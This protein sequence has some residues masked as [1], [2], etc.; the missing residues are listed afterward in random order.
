M[1]AMNPTLTYDGC[2]EQWKINLALSRIRAFD[3]P[4]DQ[5]PDLLQRLVLAMSQFQFDP[6]NGAK[7]STALYTLINHQLNSVRRAQMRE[8]QRLA[9][10]RARNIIRSIAQEDHIDLRLDVRLAVA[11][12]PAPQRSVCI[13]LLQGNSVN[14]IA[15]DLGCTWHAVRRVID[16][17]RARFSELGLDA[18][19][20]G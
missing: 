12:L 19:V 1:T 10:H 9:R 8:E 14:Q 20:G 18:W 7:E 13:G 4:K 5:W 6:N 3:F 11:A 2:I 16:C 15:A 17:V